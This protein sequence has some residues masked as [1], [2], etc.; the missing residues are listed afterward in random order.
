MIQIVSLQWLLTLHSANHQYNFHHYHQNQFYQYLVEDIHLDGGTRFAISKPG[1][2]RRHLPSHNLQPKISI[3]N[4]NFI[5][6]SNSLILI[7]NLRP[8]FPKPY[9]HLISNSNST[10]TLTL[11]SHSIFTKNSLLNI[12]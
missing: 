3:S 4:F 10:K 8:N 6:N 2:S 11:N 5:S 7:H 12:S 9:S 1:A